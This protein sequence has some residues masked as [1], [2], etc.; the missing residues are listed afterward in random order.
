MGLA[1]TIPNWQV[2]RRRALDRDG[3]RCRDCGKAGR[4]EVHHVSPLVRG[5]SNALENLRTLCVG[6]H[7][8]A[9]KRPKTPVQDAWDRMVT[10]LR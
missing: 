7:K 6:C 5:G 1:A 10:E 3:W 4:L 2:I 8:A 9:H